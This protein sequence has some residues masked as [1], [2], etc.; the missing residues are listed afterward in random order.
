MKRIMI[1]FCFLLFSAFIFSEE[2]IENLLTEEKI[3]TTEEKGELKNSE[4]NIIAVEGQVFKRE[5]GS[6][7]WQQIMSG[8]KI[9]EK[10]TVITM[11]N[12]KAL[13][14]LKTETVITVFEKTRIYFEDLKENVTK[15]TMTETGVKLF[16]GKIYSN[17]K[18]V[19][20]TG[21]N[22]RI[23]TKSATIGVRGTKFTVEYMDNEETEIEVYEGKVE[24]ESI[25]RVG[26]RIYIEKNERVRIDDSGEFKPKE[27]HT[28]E[29]PKEN[30]IFENVT[31]KITEIDTV[32]EFID[33][34][35][36]IPEKE[37]IEKIVSKINPENV[38]TEPEKDVAEIINPKE[39]RDEIKSEIEENRKGT[40]KVRIKEK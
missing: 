23:N 26:K 6:D 38:I 30:E 37:K 32:K 2:N 24:A 31:E 39:I 15:E 16:A 33:K 20:E 4:G 12:S 19:L 8:D 28:K 36:E 14:K 17:V 35:V 13:I 3:Y 5:E 22:Y 9:K 10:T 11:F 40:L 34:I 21:S 18:N 29:P 25:L 27:I 1:L 7:I